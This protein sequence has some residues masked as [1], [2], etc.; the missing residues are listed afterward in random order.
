MTA[1]MMDVR[2][3]VVRPRAT[4][5]LRSGASVS[6]TDGQSFELPVLPLRKT[7]GKPHVQTAPLRVSRSGGTSGQSQHCT[8]LHYRMLRRPE[9]RRGTV[10]DADLAIEVRKVM[11]G[12]LGADRQPLADLLCGESPSRESQH[13]GFA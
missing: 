2:A 4:V 3:S 7:A 13:I 6:A 10:R 11:I 12:R 1:I 5:I 8:A 9:R